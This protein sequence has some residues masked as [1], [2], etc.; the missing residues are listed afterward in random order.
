[1]RNKSSLPRREFLIG[2]VAGGLAGTMMGAASAAEKAAKARPAG[3]RGKA[4]MIAGG[5]SQDAAVH[6]SLHGIA[7]QM[8]KYS[9]PDGD[10]RPSESWTLQY[11]FPIRSPRAN[12]LM[13]AKRAS[14]EGIAYS[15]TVKQNDGGVTLTI[16]ANID[17]ANDR[18]LLKWK[19]Q[20][21]IPEYTA[22]P[23]PP[24]EETGVVSDTGIALTVGGLH[25]AL[26]AAKPVIPF[27]GLLDAFA[28]GVPPSGAFTLLDEFLALKPVRTAAAAGA[29]QAKLASGTIPLTG[30]Y[31]FGV[32]VHPTHVWATDRGLPLFITQGL[33]SYSL[34]AIR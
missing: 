31:Y 5:P 12:T 29:T 20:R 6:Y 2:I 3:R 17:C 15:M 10:F 14:P 23:I 1:M 32:G 24:V 21:R 9:V 25:V 28:C 7:D 13:I 18:R 16:G 22:G 27:A 19:S 4:S 26:A 11:S 8:G 30:Y 33:R 34:T